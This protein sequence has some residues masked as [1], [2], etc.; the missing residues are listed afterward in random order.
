MLTS[1]DSTVTGPYAR[2]ARLYRAAGWL[3][4][5]PVGAKAGE[6]WPP[7]RGF[8][9]HGNPDPSAAD[10]EAYI[11]THG[12]RNI[13]LRAPEGVLGLDVDAYEKGGQVKAG[14]AALAELEAK[15]GP[16][17][18]TWVSSARPAPSGIRWFRVPTELDGRPINW[19]GE[20][21]KGI[22]LIQ[23]GHRYAVVWPSTN[24][25]ADGAEYA[26]RYQHGAELGDACPYPPDPGTFPILPEAWVRGLALSYERTEKSDL[27]HGDMAA[28]W[29]K[30]RDEAPCPRVADALQ[31]AV[32]E[33]RVGRAGRH[34]TARDA[35]RTIAAYGGEGHAGAP[36]ALLEL[37]AVFVDVTAAPGRDSEGEWLRLL[38]GAVSL[39]A[40]DNVVPRTLC[41]CSVPSLLAP[42]PPNLPT[43]PDGQ[44]MVAPPKVDER[45]AEAELTDSAIAQLLC[46]EL[47]Y[48][49][50]CWAPGLGW[51]AWTGQR[52]RE[53]SEESVI[54]VVRLWL[55]RYA[56]KQLEN[57][58][59]VDREVSKAINGLNSAYRIGAITRLCRGV[60][61]VE[62]E[63][64]DAHPDLLNTQSGIV[65]LRTGQQRAHDP[66]MRFT[67][68]TDVGYVAGA[69]HP[70]WRAA[71]TAVAPDVAEWLA[72]RFGQA[73]TGHMTSDDKL[74]LLRGGGEN[75]KS[76][77]LNAVKSCL[78]SYGVFVSDKV[79]LADPK[80][81]STEM[82]VLLGARF[83]LAEELPDDG[84][85]NVKRLKDVIGTPEMTA[86]KIRQDSI[87]WQSTHSLFVSTN[88]LPK[89][90]ETDHGTWRRLVLVQF[91]FKFVS[92]QDATG[93]EHERPGD[94]T[95]RDRMKEGERQREAVLAWLV[96]GAMRWYAA[97]RRMPPLPATVAA[98]TLQWR[99]DSDMIIRFWRE[100]LTADPSSYIT[101]TDMHAEFNAWAEASGH[102]PMSIQTFKTKFEQHDETVSHRVTFALRRVREG[103]QRSFR[104]RSLLMPA[105]GAVASQSTAEAAVGKMQ[106]AWWGVRFVSG[107]TAE[108]G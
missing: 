57:V 8:T 32:G 55:A 91:P 4:V 68:I 100:C 12:E 5:L 24:P 14:A 80:A 101:G 28:W 21:A 50:H 19:P 61:H 20:A 36:G 6:K 60:L 76:T 58:F 25:E 3:G 106:R 18:P 83:A 87:T 78:G 96:A 75:G 31:R 70:D 82:T 15:Y 64:F 26:W 89:V 1:G 33:L 94:P 77:V 45:I 72:V 69:D 42:P 73:I 65:D 40:A 49:S 48:A 11:E 27:A 37:G 56:A 39:A 30:L 46:D 29:E 97:E 43:A 105:F 51:L 13:G 104:P 71:L 38:T 23:H 17:P 59:A 90:T 44:V 66:A 92:P 84:H 7:P 67:K 85:L 74:L 52:W 86:R 62:A 107:T 35:A 63:A 22:E 9:G 2:A 99:E 47:L 108:Q 102:K 34:E 53:T 103:E 81:H 88:Y 41:A 54:E 10:V 16:L 79:L 95:L 93:A 98:D